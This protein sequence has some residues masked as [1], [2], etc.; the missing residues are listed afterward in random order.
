M[1]SSG[2]DD[3]STPRPPGGPG[4]GNAGGPGPTG[5]PG[6]PQTPAGLP[7]FSGGFRT[8]DTA[9]RRVNAQL[10][11][12]ADL[13]AATQ[14][15]SSTRL[16]VGIVG[17]GT[18][19]I[20]ALGLLVSQVF[21]RSVEQD[22]LQPFEAAEETGDPSRVEET[23]M[24]VRP[25]EP[26]PEVFTDA[27][28]TACTMST[29]GASIPSSADQVRGGGLA[30]P[31]P[32]GWNTPWENSNVPYLYDD[33]GQGTH[34]E[35]GWYSVISVGRL[36]WPVEDGAY[37]GTEA[38]AVILFQCYATHFNVSQQFGNDPTVS[39]YRSEAT[40]VDGHDAWIVQ[41]TYT[42]D[43]TTTLS[44][45]QAS[46]VTTIV[47]DT[48]GGPSALVSDV[49]ADRPAHVAALETAI[50]SLEVTE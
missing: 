6:Q 42:F 32:R 31:V 15:R 29:K 30:F 38:M 9:E 34:V 1:H 22:P 12:A 37:P 40:T 3:S 23:W 28:T 21:L 20:L 19:L 46:V 33:N 17:V 4:A 47:V 24:P 45:T 48:P 5:G 41:A 49:A 39:D 7:D 14:K 16:V 25:Q 2:H 10:A 35:S 11:Q 27:P 36:D 44:T 13:N 26:P 50:A 18:V 8:Q 43:E